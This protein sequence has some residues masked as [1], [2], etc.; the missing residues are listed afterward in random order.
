[1]T[2]LDQRA[3]PDSEEGGCGSSCGIIV[4]QSLRHALG[5]QP[6]KDPYLLFDFIFRRFPSFKSGFTNVGD[7]HSLMTALID[8][9]VPAQHRS[10]V[11]LKTDQLDAVFTNRFEQAENLHGFSLTGDLKPHITSLRPNQSKIILIGSLNGAVTDHAHAVVLRG[12]NLHQISVLDP[13]FP[14]VYFNVPVSPLWIRNSGKR[15]ETLE[16]NFPYENSFENLFNP[17]KRFYIFSVTTITL[18]KSV[19]PFWL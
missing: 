2:Q 11:S 15:V 1:M 13:H 5:I 12:A 17:K 9:V 7:I 14:E 6:L 8:H 18:D 3:H 19:F 4:A 10:R 16:I